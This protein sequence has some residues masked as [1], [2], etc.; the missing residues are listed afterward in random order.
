MSL[1]IPTDGSSSTSADV[2]VTAGTPATFALESAAGQSLPSNASAEVQRKNAA[3]EYETIGYL[4]AT[5]VDQRIFVLD[6]T[7]TVRVR[8]GAAGLYGVDKA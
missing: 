8:K 2:A 7:V 1:I 3:G 5:P 6:A 4:N